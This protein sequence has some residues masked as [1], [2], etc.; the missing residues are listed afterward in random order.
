MDAARLPQALAGLVALDFAGANVTIPH[1]TAV[2]PLCDE[3]DDVARRA[4]SVN[5]LVVADGRLHGSS[6]DGLA[7][8][9]AVEASG[10][11]V[12]VVGAGGA[13]QAVAAALLEAGCASITVATRRH[14]AAVALVRHLQGAFPRAD[15]RPGAWP[16]EADGAT[17][18]VNAAPLKEE[19]VVA[20]L[21]HQQVIDLTY[22]PDGRETALVAAARTAGCEVV[23]DGLEVLV[24]QGAASFE[25]WTG[26]DA[27]VDV[28]RAAVREIG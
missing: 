19:L 10:A 12:L 1:K 16:P 4:A 22:L 9:G 20:P 8:T 21:A 24:R 28:M 3:V 2:L 5:T 23:V 26:I 17:M 11:D 18:L 27:P 14:E 6:T 25:R 13:A 7:V 15:V